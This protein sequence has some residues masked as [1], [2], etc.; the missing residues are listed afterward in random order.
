[1]KRALNATARLLRRDFQLVI[2]NVLGYGILT[3]A[4]LA[5][6]WIPDSHIWQFGLSVFSGPAIVLAALWLLI[7]TMAR[8]N[9][10]NRERPTRLLLHL[11]GFLVW[12]LIAFGICWLVGMV[13]DRQ[14]LFA[15]YLAS[16]PSQSARYLLT[17]PRIL[18][19]IHIATCMVTYYLLPVF[20][21]P[22]ASET[23]AFGL[24]GIHWRR[25]ALVLRSWQL[26]LVQAGVAVVG[27]WFPALLM[28]WTPGKRLGTQVLSVGL[29]LTLAY[30]LA[31]GAMLFNIAFVG[32]LLGSEGREDEPPAPQ[33]EPVTPAPL[34]ETS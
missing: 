29:R 6:L 14:Y 12:V 34:A 10:E 8:W 17:Y 23:A 9:G 15:G 26:W 18:S 5:W 32:V 33:P 1:M 28:E 3:A 4:A 22:L 25:Y 24:K 16:R 19:A 7:I 21:L 31:L 30:L 13:N 2:L 20:L 11:P 27:V